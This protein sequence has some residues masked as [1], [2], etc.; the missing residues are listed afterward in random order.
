MGTRR[1]PYRKDGKNPL[2]QL[3]CVL[4][5]QCDG[6]E[7]T[8]REERQ[9]LASRKCLVHTASTAAL[10]SLRRKA[11]VAGDWSSSGL[12]DSHSLH[13]FNPLALTSKIMQLCSSCQPLALKPDDTTTDDDDDLSPPTAVSTSRS[14]M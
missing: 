3:C 7:N 14:T 2:W 6:V 1:H 9:Y 8:C 4:R 12:V 13:L 5:S 11:S 10:Q